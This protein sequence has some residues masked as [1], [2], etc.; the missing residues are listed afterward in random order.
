MGDNEASIYSSAFTPAG[1]EPGAGFCACA[2]RG[3]ASSRLPSSPQLRGRMRIEL[4]TE[5]AV[6]MGGR[7]GS[8]RL[9]PVQPSKS[10][11]GD[12]GLAYAGRNS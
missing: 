7:A 5:V 10:E 4:W 6:R 1:L 2:E 9:S 3:P 8:R 11:K 12:R